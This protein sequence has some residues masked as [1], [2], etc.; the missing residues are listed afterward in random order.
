MNKTQKAALF[1][2][3]MTLL[4]LAFLLWIFFRIPTTNRI[5]GFCATAAF[6]ILFGITIIFRLRK[7]NPQEVNSDER[8]NLIKRRATT[9]AF[10]SVWILLVL[11]TVIVMISFGGI[12]NI[13]VAIFPFLNMCL[14]LAV[15][16]VYSIA[17]L[18][19]YRLGGK[20][21]E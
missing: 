1:S 12:G 8:D 13:C 9:A 20:N 10:V 7:Q 14:L 16:L 18:T 3:I 6:F 5:Y 19:Q 17:I 2:L 11:E 21:H 15:L 4:G